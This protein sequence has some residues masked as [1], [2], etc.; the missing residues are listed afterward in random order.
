VNDPHILIDDLERRT[1][2]TLRRAEAA[3]AE[4]AT[5]TGVATSEDGAVT[6]TVNAT[7]ALTDV[8]FGRAADRLSKEHL[9]KAVMAAAAQARASAARRVTNLMTPVIGEDSD[10]MRLLRE[11]LP[12]TGPRRRPPAP[13]D[14]FDQRTVLKG[15]R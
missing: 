5:V 13:D 7:G 8:T 10:A 12:Q 4:I 11:Q 1:Q 6:V 3:S 9:A 14:D 15:K 2:E